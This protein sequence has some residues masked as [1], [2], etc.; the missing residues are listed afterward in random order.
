MIKLLLLTIHSFIHSFIYSFIHLSNQFPIPS[1]V[2][3]SVK[4]NNKFCLKR[5]RNN[6]VCFLLIPE[7]D[8]PSFLERFTNLTDDLLDDPVNA[9]PFTCGENR[10]YDH[11]SPMVGAQILNFVS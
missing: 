8:K 2:N 7:D 10:P 9:E 3:L 1:F 6:L 4:P 5:T 11:N